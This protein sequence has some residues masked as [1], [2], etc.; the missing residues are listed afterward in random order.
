M[1]DHLKI[2]I[3][4]PIEIYLLKPLLFSNFQD[5]LPQGQGGINPTY[6]AEGLLRRGHQVSIYTL[7][8][9]IESPQVFFGK[10][11]SIYVGKIR[12]TP[13]NRAFDLYKSERNQIKKFIEEDKPEIVNAHWTYEYALAALATEIPAVIT[14]CDAPFRIPRFV[15][16]KAKVYWQ[17]RL[18]MA[19]LAIRRTNNLVVVSPYIAK[20][21]KTM[22]FYKEK[23]EVIPNGIDI[24]KYESYSNNTT[25]VKNAVTFFSIANGWGNL[26]NEKLLLR[27]FFQVH[28]QYPDTELWM[29]GNDHNDGGIANQWSDKHGLSNGVRFMGR[30]YH[31]ELMALIASNADIL[32][33]PSLEESFGNIFLEAG[34]Y[35]KAIIAGKYSGAVPSTLG[36]GEAGLLVD[37]RSIDQLTNAM[38]RLISN[39][40][41]RKYLGDKAKM[42]V[43]ENYSLERIIDLYEESY[44]RI[45][46]QSASE[47]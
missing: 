37:M 45:T 41:L 19:W 39:E 44:R 27:A 11:V 47:Q 42:N 1:E 18:L 25:K 7:D 24:K 22:F 31:G 30:R 13:R 33:H 34:L 17:I 10:N 16:G 26:K 2:G 15:S 28:L 6:L 12:T 46:N 8:P 35:G 20:H 40:E 23:I 4:A 9:K 21:I 3:A 36:N 38:M 14:A 43:Y 29:F 32:V 5:N